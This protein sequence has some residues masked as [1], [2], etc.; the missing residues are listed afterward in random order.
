MC[1]AD[2]VRCAIGDPLLQL[3]LDVRHPE[4]STSDWLGLPERVVERSPEVL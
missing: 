3:V 4:Q 1:F 2:S